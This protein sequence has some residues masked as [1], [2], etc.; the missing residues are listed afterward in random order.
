MAVFSNG[1]SA[2]S[3]RS[4]G[5][6]LLCS[7]HKVHREERLIKV[8]LLPTQLVRNPTTAPLCKF[9]RPPRMLVSENRIHSCTCHSVL[10]LNPWSSTRCYMRWRD[11]VRWCGPPS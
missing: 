4:R 10:H 3:L 5:V 6:S 1:L 7:Q 11:L 9:T 8:E 2:L